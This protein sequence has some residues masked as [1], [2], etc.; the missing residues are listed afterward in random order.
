MFGAA[1]RTGFETKRDRRI[2][3]WDSFFTLFFLCS[4]SLLAIIRLVVK[5]VAL[6][7]VPYI[8]YKAIELLGLWLEESIQDEQKRRE[9]CHPPFVSHFSL[10]LFSLL[11]R[12]WIRLFCSHSKSISLY[13]FVGQSVAHGQIQDSCT[14]LTKQ[15]PHWHHHCRMRIIKMKT[16][17][18]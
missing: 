7:V 4:S 10:G 17:C 11:P 14:Y 16:S 3:A 18:P 5:A 13:C 12:R 6:E 9:R 2:I 15:L 1:F 8:Y